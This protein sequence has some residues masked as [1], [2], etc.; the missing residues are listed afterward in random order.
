MY[1]QQQRKRN[2]GISGA[3]H[4]ILVKKGDLFPFKACAHFSGISLIENANY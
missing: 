3:L 2:F 1:H 4:Y